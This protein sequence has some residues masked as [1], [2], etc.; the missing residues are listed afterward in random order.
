MSIVGSSLVDTVFQRLRNLVRIGKLK[1]V[2]DFLLIEKTI[3]T[4]TYSLNNVNKL[5]LF[6][7]LSFWHTV[8][9]ILYK[10]KR[11]IMKNYKKNTVLVVLLLTVIGANAQQWNNLNSRQEDNRYN[12]RNEE[13]NDGNR[14][15]L[16]RQED[17][18]EYGHEDRREYQPNVYYHNDR[19]YHHEIPR[20]VYRNFDYVP[21]RV[22]YYYYPYANVYFNPYNR[23]YYFPYRGQWVSGFDLPE[24]INLNDNY[25]EVYCNDNENI[26]AYNR[27]HIDCF[28]LR[29]AGPRFH[30]GIRF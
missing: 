12:H 16:Y 2:K 25:R 10:L 26:W 17:R 22:R 9:N 28:A 13:R 5:N 21:H 14:Q 23:I 6:I 8:R 15:H 24:G 11:K 19:E 1:W 18:R 7:V 27:S 30:V 4:C 29:I 3:Y 20:M